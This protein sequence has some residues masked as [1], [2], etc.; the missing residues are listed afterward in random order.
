MQ[1]GHGH[2]DDATWRDIFTS[3]RHSGLSWAC[4]A[5]AIAHADYLVGHVARATSNA[6]DPSLR[7][8]GPLWTETAAAS[9]RLL[10][11]SGAYQHL[12]LDLPTRFAADESAIR[13]W[14]RAPDPRSPA[15]TRTVADL[16]EVDDNFLLDDGARPGRIARLV[17]EAQ[18]AGVLRCPNMRLEVWHMADG[19]GDLIG[20][21]IAVHRDQVILASEQL[22]ATDLIDESL[23]GIDAAVAVLREAATVGTRLVTNANG[24]AGFAEQLQD[25]LRSPA[26]FERWRASQP[27]PDQVDPEMGAVDPDAVVSGQQQDLRIN[28]VATTRLPGDIFNHR[29]RL[30]AGNHWELRDVR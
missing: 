10:A 20:H 29:M 12:A 11:S 27:D 25:A 1:P 7:R 8:G 23:T 3:P 21:R 13:T 15:G 2:T 22:D 26:L 5:I 17:D 14:L 19:E 30:L 18:T 6:S 28:L 4:M 9:Y 24:A 16:L